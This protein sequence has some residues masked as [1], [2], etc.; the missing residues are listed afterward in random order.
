MSQST[1]PLRYSG[2][3]PPA[4]FNLSRYALGPA[5]I[6][7][8]GK[9]GLIIVTDA[10]GPAESD[11]RWTYGELDE[12][13]RRIAAGLLAAGLARGD[14]LMIRMPNGPDYVLLFFGAIAAGILPLPASSQLT[15]SEA[16]FLLQD[17]EA[18]AV[19]LGGGMPVPKA[20]GRQV[21]ILDELAIAALKQ[22]PPLPDYADTAAKDPAY[23]VYT[24]GTSS[25]PKGVLHAQGDIWGRRPMVA[26]W[27]DLRSRD[28]LLHAGAFNWSFT[29]GVG[30]MD[31]WANGATGVLYAGPRDRAIWPKLIGRVHATLFAAV[32]S[33]YRQILKYSPPERGALKGLR[34]GLAAGEGLPSSVLEEWRA[35]TGLEIYEAFGMSECGT[36]A[37]NRP[38]MPIRPGSLGKPQPGRAIA[39]LPPEGGTEPLPK[40]EVGL[41]SIHRDDPGLMLG[42]WRRPEEN[43]EAFR[44]DWFVSGDLAAADADGYLWHHGRADDVMKAGGYRVSPAEVEE[45]LAGH[46][47]IAEVAVTEHEVRPGVK[48][49]AA[50][51]VPK[52]PKRKDPAS[53]L[54]YAEPRLAAYKRPREVFFVEAL[55][56][57]ANGKIMRRAL[58]R[59]ACG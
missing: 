49:I 57:T 40:G 36:F 50:F 1:A 3:L 35:H 10:A 12:L 14:R 23:L 53:I 9:T 22:V 58:G 52:D 13:V 16:D 33:I 2:E 51:V 39:V 15:E 28:V 46:P 48:V 27:S 7:D 6:R 47:D 44:G 34:Y 11:A 30:L 37:S 56:R 5:A 41:L 29:L 18:A 26:G 43:A 32:P 19:A 31:P 45:A 38:G 8:P 21:K 17:C 55:P 54:A 24:S 4:R 25:R 42:Y 59:P 20:A